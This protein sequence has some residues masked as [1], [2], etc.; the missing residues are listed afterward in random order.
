MRISVIIPTYNGACRIAN[1]LTCLE[2]QSCVPDEVVVAIDGSTDG[3][4]ALLKNR[5]WQLPSLKVVEQANGGRAAIRNFGAR[6]ASGDLLVFMDDDMEPDSNCIA[7]HARHHEHYPGSILTG[8]QIDKMD[9]SRTDIQLFKAELSIRWSKKLAAY[10]DKPLPNDLGYIT[11]ANFSIS[12][13]LFSSLGTFDVRLKDHEDNDLAQRALAADIPLFYNHKAFAW[14]NDPVTGSS[15]VLR[16][17]QYQEAHQQKAFLN[18]KPYH[19]AP[20]VIKKPLFYFFATK[21]WIRFLDK[22]VLKF[23]LPK[24]FRY[25]LYDFIVTANG[26]Y[27]P[28]QVQL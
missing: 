24:I 2:Q 21:Y 15:Y 28:E 4:A 12:Q 5:Q 16:L 6:H 20:A 26:V 22:G 13:K 1:V 10:D 11:A 7:V 8:A 18:G 17:R 14:H 19:V 27:F 3:T 9:G 23:F 25:R